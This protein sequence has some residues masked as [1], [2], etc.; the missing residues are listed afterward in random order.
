MNKDRELDMVV[1]AW[2]PSNWGAEEQQTK[3]TVSS[4]TQRAQSQPEMHG[5][6]V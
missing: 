3:G 5:A 1:Q 6:P 4:L 2:V